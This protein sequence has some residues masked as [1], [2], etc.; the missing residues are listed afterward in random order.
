M[1]F[2]DVVE[3]H[4]VLTFLILKVHE[5]FLINILFIHWKFKKH[6]QSFGLLIN[7]WKRTWVYLQVL[8]S[9]VLKRVRFIDLFIPFFLN[10][11]FRGLLVLIQ[12]VTF[13]GIK[14]FPRSYPI[15]T[16]CTLFLKV[17]FFLFIQVRFGV[18]TAFLKYSLLRLRKRAFWSWSG[19]RRFIK[20][21]LFITTLIGIV[22]FFCRIIFWILIIELRIAR[23][24]CVGIK[25]FIFSLRLFYDHRHISFFQVILFWISFADESVVSLVIIVKLKT[26]ERQLVLVIPLKQ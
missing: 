12:I 17:I 8:P 14:S 23:S 16:G 24:F 19:T 25:R 15:S 20:R 11:L 22:L 4:Y 5:F 3:W 9:P 10:Y 13:G 2:W 7:E 18:S 21:F 1:E 6:F 26:W